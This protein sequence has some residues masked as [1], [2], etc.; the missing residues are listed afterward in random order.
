V[1]E[2]IKYNLVNVGGTIWADIYFGDAFVCSYKTGTRYIETARKAVEEA[3]AEVLKKSFIAD[4][5]SF[6]RTSSEQIMRQNEE[7]WMDNG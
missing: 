1:R 2:V 6:V 7:A 4:D 5:Y 3:I